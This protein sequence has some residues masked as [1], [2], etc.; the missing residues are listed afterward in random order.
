MCIFWYILSAFLQGIMNLF[1]GIIDRFE[2]PDGGMVRTLALQP[3]NSTKDMLWF[4]DGSPFWT[5][6]YADVV[7]PRGAENVVAIDLL[8]RGIRERSLEHATGTT[9]EYLLRR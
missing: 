5:K 1:E 3:F 6:R 7:V 8:V 4:L 9:P 2:Q